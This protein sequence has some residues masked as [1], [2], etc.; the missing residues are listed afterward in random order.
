[1]KVFA[2]LCEL[3]ATSQEIITTVTVVPKPPTII[4]APPRDNRQLLHFEP[5]SVV[6]SLARQSIDGA[7]HKDAPLEL[8]VQ[9]HENKPQHYRGNDGHEGGSAVNRHSDNVTRSRTLR[10]HWKGGIKSA[11]S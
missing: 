7:F 3:Q 4:E 10:I 8:L 6:S 2:D 1:M 9:P 5:K 11:S